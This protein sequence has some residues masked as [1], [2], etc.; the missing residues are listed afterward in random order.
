MSWPALGWASKQKP[1]RVADKM[2]LIALADR[3]NEEAD[4]AYPSIAWIAEFACLDRKTVVA[5]LGRLEAAGYISDSGERVGK[6]KQVK[7]YHLALNGPEKGNPKTEPLPPKDT[8]FSAKE[9]QKRDTEPFFEPSTVSNETDNSPSE[10]F[11]CDD[12]LESWNAVAVECGLPTMRKLTK[13]RRTAFRVRK[14]E[15]PDIADWQSA[16][17][18]LR[19]TKWMHGDNDRK[20]RANADF[21]LQASSFTRLV[22]GTY[23]QAS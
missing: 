17:R 12:F 20:W 1:G 9:S 6:T 14:R 21:F 10:D 4:V 8:V 16:F 11:T 13:E 19:T 5:A 3:H 2:V 7:A 23:A 18:C 15:Y 22:E